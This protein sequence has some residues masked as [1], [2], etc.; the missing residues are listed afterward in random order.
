MSL[1][2]FRKNA[3]S[4]IY[5]FYLRK[6]CEIVSRTLQC[7]NQEKNSSFIIFIFLRERKKFVNLSSNLGI[8][9]KHKK[10]LFEEN[11][12]KVIVSLANS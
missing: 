12:T 7:E 2:D 1:F 11:P 10:K 3:I 8:G 6:F 4:E 5:R 9:M